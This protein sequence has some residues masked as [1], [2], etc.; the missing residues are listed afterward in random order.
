MKHSIIKDFSGWQRLFEAEGSF[1]PPGYMGANPA[2]A[3]ATAAVAPQGTGSTAS[4]ASAGGTSA[5]GPIPSVKMPTEAIA[6]ADGRLTL[7]DR[8]AIQTVLMAGTYLDAT[9]LSD[10]TGKLKAS[11]DGVIGRRSI[12]ALTKFRQ[13]HGIT[14]TAAPT[15]RAI[16]QGTL[17]KINEIIKDPTKLIQAAELAEKPNKTPDQIAAEQET[18]KA[19]EAEAL[20]RK[21]EQD[22]AD[23]AEADKKIA[24]GYDSVQVIMDLI[25][26]QFIKS[27]D[28]FHDYEAGFLRKDR[29]E[30]A[31]DYFGGWFKDNISPKVDALPEGNPNKADF[32]PGGETLLNTIKTGIINKKN[33]VELKYTDKTG[34]QK[35]IVINADF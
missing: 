1:A 5:T 33:N 29:V 12:A 30:G 25:S 3:T 35:S 6:S 27:K 18:A 7:T 17:A 11:N 19:A 16:G 32:G 26:A 23:K 24:A 20:K 14:D 21:Q 13:K 31:A 22:A 4:T 15:A 2:N 28:F 34:N 8:I 10:K 9:F